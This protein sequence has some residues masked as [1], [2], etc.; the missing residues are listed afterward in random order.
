MLLFQPISHYMFCK[1]LLF[2]IFVIRTD[3]QSALQS[4]GRKSDDIVL[5]PIDNIENDMMKLKSGVIL[6]RR[7]MLAGILCLSTK[8]N[9]QFSF[10]AFGARS[11]AMGGATVAMQDYAA[12]LVNVAGLAFEEHKTFACSVRNNFM[13]KQLSAAAIGVVMPFGARCATADG[14]DGAGAA[15]PT[16]PAENGVAAAQF[17]NQGNMNFYQ[18]GVKASYALRLA[19][20]VA[21]GVEFDYFHAGSID[22]YYP[23]YHF[24]SFD[25]GL[26]WKLSQRFVVGAVACNPK[27]VQLAETGGVMPRGWYG[28]GVTYRPQAEIL[29]AIQVECD[30]RK[31]ATVRVGVEYC[32]QECIFLRAG[33]ATQ[34]ASYTFGVGYEQ[35]HYGMDIAVQEHGILGMSSQLSMF[36][37]F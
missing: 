34:P 36:Y 28:I 3:R 8:G 27:A 14:D 17:V 20:N 31:E 10:P 22:A 9:A 1:S 18:Q 4:T 11:L 2:L 7:M 5:R 33:F 16:T 37:R 25:M 19:R 32:V 21:L 29:T 6:I 12:A 30:N 13:M 23:S 15:V 35:K 26:Q 24:L